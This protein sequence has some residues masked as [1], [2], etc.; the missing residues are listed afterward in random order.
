MSPLRV[1]LF[2]E[3]TDRSSS[4]ESATDPLAILWNRAVCRLAGIPQFDHV[5]GFSKGSLVAMDPAN[6]SLSSV[7]ESFDQL[8]LRKLT[9]L[10]FDA[11]VV[12]WDLHPGWNSRATYCRWSETKSIYEGI[13]NSPAA[14]P[15]AWM[16]KAGARFAEMNSRASPEDRVGPPPLEVNSIQVICMDKTFEDL[17]VFDRANILRRALEV[18][19]ERVKGWPRNFV[20]AELGVGAAIAAV[21][22]IRPKRQVAKLVRNDFPA[23]KHEWATLILER[24][25]QNAED[26]Q[27]LRNHPIVTRL[28]EV[29][30]R[31]S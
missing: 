1:A 12:A 29:S 14:I 20:D 21:R 25:L 3:G 11:A 24:A 31:D 16:K 5:I 4:S 6:R 15:S 17:L 7:G 26:A 28:R 9:T 8:F 10:G 2:V 27:M 30:D 22:R 18:Q 13:A 19:G 23:A